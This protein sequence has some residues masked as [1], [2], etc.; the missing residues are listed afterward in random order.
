MAGKG[1]DGVRRFDQARRPF[2]GK[3]HERDS[4]TIGLEQLSRS[5]TGLAAVDERI[6]RMPGA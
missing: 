2:L 6:S 4:L 3:T 1:G 5:S